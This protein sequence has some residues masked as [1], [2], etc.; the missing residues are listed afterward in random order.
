MFGLARLRALGD[1]ALRLGRAAHNAATLVPILK[2]FQKSK[3][4]AAQLERDYIS[5]STFSLSF[6]QFKQDLMRRWLAG[7]HI[8]APSFEDL[9]RDYTTFTRTNFKK[10]IETFKHFLTSTADL[11]LPQNWYPVARSMKRR[12]IYH[13][14]PTNSGKT[15]QALQRLK[16]AE[17]GVY[18]GP[19]R[20][21]A[22]EV[23]DKLNG[24]GVGC[25]LRTGEERRERPGA[26]HISSTIE[27]CQVDK[28][29]DV[30]IIDE[31][32][33]LGDRERG[34]AW[35]RAFLGLPAQELH[36]CGDSTAL[37]IVERLLSATGDEL[38]VKTYERLSPL[39]PSKTSLG[40]ALTRVEPGDCVITFS[41]KQIYSVKRAIETKT[42]YKCCVVYGRLP[43]EARAQQAQ[44]FNDPNSGYDVLVASDA[45]GMG[46][47]L[48]IRRIVFETLEK[49]DGVEDVQV[50][51]AQVRQISGRAGRYG[52]R[53]PDGLVTCL[54]DDDMPD[55][56]RAL[57]AKPVDLSVCCCC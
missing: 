24:E 44:L 13:M 31:I 45:V 29:V 56:L 42:N 35:T 4:L 17:T 28:R 39:K 19:L 12:V 25:H 8:Q 43:P 18:C 11:R 27:M 6:H 30:G 53:Y 23:Y 9:L 16:T 37:K 49:F 3:M 36:L 57:E 32:Q 1:S 33:L 52:S 54:A 20:L 2:S 14:G 40:E 50:P 7:E 51:E 21:L 26:K 22:L 41:R 55:M 34:W 5:E 38:E 46:L 47:N 10:D 48:N 15:F